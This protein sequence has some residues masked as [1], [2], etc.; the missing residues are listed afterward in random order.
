MTISSGKQIQN[1]QGILTKK[2]MNFILT[3]KGCWDI[4]L[5]AKHVSSMYVC[6][7]GTKWEKT[8]C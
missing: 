7:Y 4:S 8:N 6:L 3:T 5:T 1:S 2:I